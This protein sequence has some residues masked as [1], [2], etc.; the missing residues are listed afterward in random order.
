MLQS[1]FTVTITPEDLH[2]AGVMLVTQDL[3][4]DVIGEMEAIF[5]D[6][7]FMHILKAALL[8]LGALA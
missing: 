3:L 2:S 1:A 6:D 5:Q 8:D 7:Y 4:N